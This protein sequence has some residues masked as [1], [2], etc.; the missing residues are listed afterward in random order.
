MAV[1]G[2]DD[3]V[4]FGKKLYNAMVSETM[5][6]LALLGVALTEIFLPSLNT[7]M[8]IITLFFALR[9]VIYKFVDSHDE[10][11]VKGDIAKVVSKDNVEK[12]RIESDRIIALAK[13][14][15][16][17]KKLENESEKIKLQ[18]DVF[19]LKR[20]I[21]KQQEKFRGQVLITRLNNI[22][23]R[24]E[25]AMKLAL[26]DSSVEVTKDSIELFK[27]LDEEVDFLL[28]SGISAPFEQIAI[29]KEIVGTIPTSTSNV[30]QKFADIN[31]GEEEYES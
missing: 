23:K 31:I 3:S 18:R 29:D 22:E 30:E 1:K 28:T 5:T 15:K 9:S 10:R 24:N 4:R 11:R 20:D 16:E 8:I 19:E 14:E 13:Y 17:Y 27:N 25:F 7:I 2:I 21:V 6:S 12:E 26:A